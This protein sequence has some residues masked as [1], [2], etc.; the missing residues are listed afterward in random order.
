MDQIATPSGS[1]TQGSGVYFIAHC[2]YHGRYHH[3]NAQNPLGIVF[4]QNVL[5]DAGLG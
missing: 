1:E 3:T 5:I 4:G 2:I